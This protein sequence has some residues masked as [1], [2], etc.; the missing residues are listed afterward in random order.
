MIPFILFFILGPFV[1]SLSTSSS[2]LSNISIISNSLK[3]SN[4]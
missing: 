2:F 3:K 4:Q 1:C